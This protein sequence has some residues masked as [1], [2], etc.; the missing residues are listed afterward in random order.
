MFQPEVKFEFVRRYCS[1]ANGWIVFVD[2]DAS[3][4][5][6]TGGERNNDAARIRQKQMQTAAARVRREFHELGM[7]IGGNRQKWLVSNGFP[8]V[9]GDRDVL[10]F[11][12]A[13]KLCIIAE[14]EGVSSGQPEQKLYKAIGQIVMAAS[15]CRLKGWEQRLVL[16]VHGEQITQ[17][18]GRVAVLEKLGISAVSIAI[19]QLQDKWLFGTSLI[20][21]TGT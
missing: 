3:E 6:R 9:E 14:V 13:M 8:T 7:T 11:H 17:H 12:D 15:C 1:P 19:D 21:E 18:L 5:G 16:V 20:D 4:E 10:A 2:I